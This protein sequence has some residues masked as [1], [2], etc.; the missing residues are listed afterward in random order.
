MFVLDKLWQ[1]GL[2]PNERYTR[3]GSEYHKILLRICEEG[4]YLATELTEEGKAHFDAYR[5]AQIELSVVAEKEV[6]IEAFRLGAR[7]MLDV[8]GDYKGQFQGIGDVG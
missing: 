7:M 6:F 3:K 1:E 4:D 5:D 8:V 2:S